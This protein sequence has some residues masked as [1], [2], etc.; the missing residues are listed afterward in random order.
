MIEKDRSVT[1][2][3]TGIWHATS[4]NCRARG[5]ATHGSL[6]IYQR[7]H[8]SPCDPGPVI[9]EPRPAKSRQPPFEK[10]G[11]QGQGKHRD[12]CHW[13]SIIQ[14]LQW[15]HVFQKDPFHHNHDVA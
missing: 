9:R 15:R 1:S 3:F 11:R 13:P 14:D 8:H 12:N 4:G 6:R 7:E 2:H 5:S 10:P